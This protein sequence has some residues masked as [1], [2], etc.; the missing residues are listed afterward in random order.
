M[1]CDLD[2]VPNLWSAL[3][4]LLYIKP[5]NAEFNKNVDKIKGNL[6]KMVIATPPSC[7]ILYTGQT[8]KSLQHRKY[9]AYQCLFFSR[10]LI[11]SRNNSG[12]SRHILGMLMETFGCSEQLDP[13]CGSLII[14]HLLM[15]WM[16]Q[17]QSRL[18][19]AIRLNPAV[20]PHVAVSLYTRVL[21][22]VGMCVDCSSLCLLHCVSVFMHTRFCVYFSLYMCAWIVCAHSCMG[23]FLYIC[24]CVYVWIDA[25][26]HGPGHCLLHN[27]GQ[28]VEKGW[29]AFWWIL[30]QTPSTLGSPLVSS[31]FPSLLCRFP[32]LGS[33]CKHRQAG[34]KRILQCGITMATAMVSDIHNA[35]SGTVDPWDKNSKL[36]LPLQHGD[37]CRE[38]SVPDR[39]PM[40]DLESIAENTHTHTHTHTHRFPCRS[41]GALTEISPCLSLPLLPPPVCG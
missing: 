41:S 40:S 33:C 36:G 32:W 8:P 16:F 1:T 28:T 11:E 20:L 6:A 34:C 15:A 25:L 30:P 26:S 19:V 12:C 2:S 5:T 23:V 29:L 31:S 17:Q 18:L 24:I 14:E 21:K 10:E 7:L 27:E 38:E 35:E 4:Y 22:H 37:T 9:S 13:F 39:E 3:Q